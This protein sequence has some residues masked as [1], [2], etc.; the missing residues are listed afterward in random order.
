MPLRPDTLLAPK[1][2]THHAPISEDE[3]VLMSADLGR[4][5]A[6]NAVGARVWEL[7]AEGPRTIDSLSAT[8]CDEFD[9]ELPACRADVTTFVQSLIDSGIVHEI[10]R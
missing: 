3:A 10:E 7:L 2:E 5:F 1:G 4:Y 6:V 8:I 9:V